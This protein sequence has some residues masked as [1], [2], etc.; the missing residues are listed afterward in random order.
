MK[1]ALLVLVSVIAFYAYR[2][3]Y[4]PG[5]PRNI[6]AL[7]DSIT[8]G[9]YIQ[10]MK[11]H[12]P[13]CSF[14]YFG[15]SGK[16]ARY[17]SGQTQRSLEGSPD[18][19]I[20]L[21][22]VNDLASGRSM[23]SIQ[24]GLESI[25]AKVHASGARVVAVEVLPWMGYSRSAGHGVRTQILNSWIRNSSSA[26]VVVDASEMGLDGEMLGNLT[27]DGIHPNFEGKRALAEII[28]EEVY[29]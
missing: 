14:G 13:K 17:I 3:L 20:V 5:C 8:A 4:R 7:G 10:H 2:R 11:T 16:G 28:Y 6:V 22:G 9:N 26:D 25:Y 29:R 1:P 18:D 19:V 21:V 24:D 23:A 12:L 15:F 27:D